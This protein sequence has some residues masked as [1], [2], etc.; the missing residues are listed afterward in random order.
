MHA[1]D[2]KTVYIRRD[3]DLFSAHEARTKPFVNRSVPRCPPADPPPAAPIPPIRTNTRAPDLPAQL[4]AAARVFSTHPVDPNSHHH[5][6]WDTAKK[7]EIDAFRA[8]DCMR[9][10]TATD[11]PKGTQVFDFVWRVTYKE[12]RGNGKAPARARFCIA[13]NRDW[14]KESNVPT[15]PVTPQRAIRTLLAAAVILGFTLRTEDFLREHLQSDELAEPIYVRIPPE[16]GEPFSLVRAFSRA[17]YGKDDAGRH[18]H[19]SLQKRFLNIPNVT[20]STA[21]ETIYI[22]ALHGAIAA[23]VDDTLS[24]GD[25]LFDA[26][27]C[28]V[29][30]Q[31]KTHRPDHG[32]VQFAGISATTDDDGVHC[33]AGHYAASLVPIP[34]P[35]RMADALPHPRALSALAA[36]LI[37]VGR[38]GRPDVLT[39]ATQSANLTASTG[40]DARHANDTLALLTNRPLSL[41]YPKLNRA[42][43]RLAVHADYSGS[44]L[45]NAD[46]CQVGYMAALKDDTNRF[47]L[48]NWASHKPSRVCRGSTAGE[49]IA[50]A[51]GFAA[52]LD[53]RQLLQE[54]LDQRIP[55]E[56][57]TDWATAYDLITSFKDPADLTGKNDLFTLRCA[58]LDGS[59]AAIHHVHGQHNPADPLFKPTWSRPKPNNALKVALHTG[60]LDTPTTSQATSD[61][62]RTSPRSGSP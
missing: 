22:W 54:L 32:T 11:V 7:A 40:A 5:P 45:S 25:K 2:G 56:T 1:L 58:L 52:A 26:A 61:T 23:Y 35:E 46:K 30:E 33:S 44:A 62:Y 42:S 14:H 20:L 21:F 43:L 36:K 17:I 12:N 50:L 19:F 34:E 24:M 15:S 31:Y 4:P 18:F 13:G 3:G 57:Y 28:T 55:V 59:M 37:W 39:N 51:D 29:M 6:R 8:M 10:V 48:L 9:A 47:A 27:I 38:C 41:H 49:L 53:V 60:I 16:A